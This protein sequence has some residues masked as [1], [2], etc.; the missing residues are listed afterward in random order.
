M[1]CE[2]LL[3]PI[4]DRLS[5]V[6]PEW[7]VPVGEADSIVETEAG[8]LFGPCPSVASSGPNGSRL[9]CEPFVGADTTKYV[10]A[11]ICL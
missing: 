2:V 4:V 9:S 10:M 11:G 1:R 3:S 8:S 5:G 6:Q 7:A